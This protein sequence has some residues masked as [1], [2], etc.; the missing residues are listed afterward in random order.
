MTK[1][2]KCNGKKIGPDFETLVVIAQEEEKK[3]ESAF[4]NGFEVICSNQTFSP[5]QYC[6][7]SC[8]YVLHWNKS[9]LT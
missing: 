6:I 3:K 9:Q 5:S 4:Y 7:K 2:A 8:L 1:I